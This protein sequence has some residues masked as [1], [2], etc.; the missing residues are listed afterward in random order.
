MMNTEKTLTFE[1]AESIYETYNNKIEWQKLMN[2]VPYFLI[3][4]KELIHSSK[5]MPI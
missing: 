5:T 2:C 3:T 4:Q 1:R